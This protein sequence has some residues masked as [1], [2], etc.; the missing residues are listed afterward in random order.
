[1]EPLGIENMADKER[2]IRE[3]GVTMCYDALAFDN[4][5]GMFR[6]GGPSRL[7]KAQVSAMSRIYINRT[8]SDCD[9]VLDL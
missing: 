4:L 1:M 8:T 2:P 9:R 6:A 5:S 3:K 7:Q